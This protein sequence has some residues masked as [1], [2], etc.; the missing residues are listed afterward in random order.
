[1]KKLVLLIIFCASCHALV[2]D[3]TRKQFT[4][5]N[6][7]VQ[8]H[9]IL[10]ADI[11]TISAM[12]MCQRFF[13][14]LVRVQVIFSLATHSNSNTLLLTRNAVGVFKAHIGAREY[15]FSRFPEQQNEW[16]SLCWTWD[17]K[18][19]LTQLWLNGKRSSQKLIL[20]EALVT[21]TPSTMLGQEQDTY[22]GG[23]DRQ[24]SFEGDVTDV[25]FWDYVTSPCEIRSYMKGMSF[26]PGNVLSWK[27]LQYDI[28][29][30]VFVQNSDFDQVCKSD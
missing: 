20:S 18:T 6:S 3:L 21:G 13:S 27:A 1:M 4:F 26:V 9:V 5:P 28:V 24:Q 19:G 10:H 8:P 11:N 14:E 15:T 12:T 23:F 2:Q 29:G 16:N 22:G 7:A 25:H 17:S 30:T